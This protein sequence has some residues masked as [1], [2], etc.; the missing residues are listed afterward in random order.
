MKIAL[1][2]LYIVFTLIYLRYA[3]GGYHWGAFG[4]MTLLLFL[5]GLCFFVI[6]GKP[7]TENEKLFLK[8]AA[9]AS[10]ARAVYSGYCG[11]IDEDGFVIYNTDVFQF[12]LGLFFGAFILYIAYKHH[13][14]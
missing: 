8:F 12:G 4:K 6:E 14:T 7:N 10:I 9:L 1:S 13:K 2:F 5:A 11:F 3:D